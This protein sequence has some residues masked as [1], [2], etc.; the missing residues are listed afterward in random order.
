ML[1]L[2]I[3]EPQLKAERWFSSFIQVK[4][5]R[6]LYSLLSFK[7]G[8]TDE[9]SSVRPSMAESTLFSLSS[10]HRCTAVLPEKATGCFPPFT[11]LS[12]GLD[13]LKDTEKPATQLSIVCIMFWGIFPL[14]LWGPIPSAWIRPMGISAESQKVSLFPSPS[15]CPATWRT[16]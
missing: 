2:S 9:I 14:L 6:K 13:A 15:P 10:L 3:N 1:S 12:S 8:K 4:C 11:L 16:P 7:L 5:L